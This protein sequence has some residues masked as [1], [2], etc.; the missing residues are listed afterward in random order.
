MGEP[1]SRPRLLPVALTL[2]FLL[3][4]VS[5]AALQQPPPKFKAGVSVVPV[6]VVVR[7]SNKRLVRDLTRDDFQILE[8]G[9]ARP[10]VDFRSTDQAP[11]SIALLL[12]TSGSMRDA[13]QQQATAVIAALLQAMDARDE[14]ALFTFD[15][16]LRQETPFT[17]DDA[18][19]QQAL[20]KAVM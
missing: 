2:A 15:K 18:V 16:T 17:G 3:H 5:G 9:V 20:A 10:I 6:T 1:V 7:D 4:T 8:D 13:N 11:I 14:A 19:I 12:D